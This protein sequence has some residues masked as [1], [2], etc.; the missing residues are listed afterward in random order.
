MYT[1]I[2]AKRGKRGF[3]NTFYSGSLVKGGL[4]IGRY[5][6]IGNNTFKLNK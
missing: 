1:V 4:K 5:K 2:L 6:Y 3:Y